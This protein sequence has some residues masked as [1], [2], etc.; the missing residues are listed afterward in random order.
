MLPTP[1]HPIQETN[2]SQ[3]TVLDCEPLHDLKG[4]LANLLTELPKK[5]K[6]PTLADEI[7]AVIAVDLEANLP[8]VGGTIV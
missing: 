5:I 8:G 3:Y 2:L 7:R 1:T 4:H 6:D